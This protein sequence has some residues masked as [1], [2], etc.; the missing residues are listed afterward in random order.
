MAVFE[1]HTGDWQS[2]GENHYKTCPVCG[3]EYARG[4]HAGG[5]ADDCQHKKVM[6]HLR[7]GIRRSRPPRPDGAC[8]GWPPPAPRMETWSTG[9]ARC[10]P[11][12]LCRRFGGNRTDQT[13]LSPR[14]GTRW[15]LSNWT[16][17]TDYASASALFTLRARREPYRFGRRRRYLPNTDPDCVNDG[18]T[19]YT[20]SA[21]F[22][23]LIYTDTRSVL[24]PATGHNWDTAWQS[25]RR[26]PLARVPERKLP[27][28]RQHA[29]GRL[30]RP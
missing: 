7:A 30:C 15:R 28:D 21:T 5:S 11:S 14:W 1:A 20:A 13:W 3:A 2:D 16:W 9:A 17:S 6:R 23:G 26:G 10:V 18:R 12:Q 8:R 24:L 19:D 25:R 4:A 22:D 29:E 27:R